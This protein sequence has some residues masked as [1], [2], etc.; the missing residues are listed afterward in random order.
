MNRRLAAILTADVVGYSRLIREDEAGTLAELKSLRQ[1]LIDPIL[2]AHDGR[3]VKLLGDG[4][5]VEFTSVVAAVQAALEIQDR[6]TDQKRGLALRI[7]VHLGDVV[8][9]ED[10]IYGDGV[11]LS[12]RLEALSPVGGVCISGV[13]HDEIRNRLDTEFQNIGAQSLKNID[14]PVNVWQ[15]P[16]GEEQGSVLVPAPTDRPSVAVLAFQNM[17][18]DPEQDFFADGLA[19]EIINTLSQIPSLLV[20][21]RHSSF[22]YRG[23]QVDIRTVGRELGVRY[24]LEG[25][26]RTAADRLRVTAQL[27]DALDGSQLW[28]DRYNRNLDDVFAIQDEI[29][30]EIATALRIRLSDGEQA[31]YWIQGTKS[32]AAWQCALPAFDIMMRVTRD[33]IKKGRDLCKQ[34]ISIDESYAA[35]HALLAQSYWFDLRFGFYDDRTEALSEF[36]A[37]AETSIELDPTLANGH[38][39]RAGQ[40]LEAG[41][42][43]GAIEA[44]RL[45]VKLSPNNSLA[46][47]SMGRILVNAGLPEEAEGHLRL[48]LRLNPFAPAVAHGILANALEL[49]GRDSEAIDSLFRAVERNPDYLAGHLRLSSLLGLSGRLDEARIHVEEVQRLKPDIDDDFLVSFY[50]S[51]SPSALDRFKDGLSA[52]GLTS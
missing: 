47:T 1:E 6:T 36:S 40:R 37:A 33:D 13:V 14:Q 42:V 17:S 16:A 32:V 11:N 23:Q 7:G 50:R 25:G 35:A 43:Q 10:D 28:S 27:T 31:Q 2:S 41:D 9:D 44:G 30:R 20:I 34:A 38:M 8:V 39:M 18:S 49:L 45:A 52:A 51:S 15:W 46:R 4:V 24:V 12:A 19:E 22:A 5:L 21:A 29:T 48:A 3:V 26:V